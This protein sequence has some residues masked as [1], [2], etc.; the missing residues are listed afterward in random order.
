MPTWDGLPVADLGW[1]PPGCPSTWDGL[2]RGLPG[3]VA[4]SHQR[5][6]EA[7]RALHHLERPGPPPERVEIDPRAH[8]EI[9]GEAALQL[10]RRAIVAHDGVHLEVEPEAA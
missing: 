3:R 4:G 2:P 9:A 5:A 7:R 1:R 6:Q 8:R 10:G